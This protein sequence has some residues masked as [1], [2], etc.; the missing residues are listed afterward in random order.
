MFQKSISNIKAR[1]VNLIK[2]RPKQ[3]WF[4][5]NEAWILVSLIVA[6]YFVFHPIE[7]INNLRGK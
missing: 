7:L 6:G 5:S 4:G 2:D 3:S 1:K